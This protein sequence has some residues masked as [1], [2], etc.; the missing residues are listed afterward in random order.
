MKQREIDIAAVFD[1]R[2][3]IDTAMRRAAEAA[4][5]VHRAFGTPIP[6]WQD[7]RVRMVDPE[8]LVD[9]PRRRATRRSKRK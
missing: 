3:A 5:V 9:A 8:S 6:V 7:G 2:R 4:M 1:R